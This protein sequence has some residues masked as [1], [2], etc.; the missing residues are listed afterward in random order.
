MEDPDR[1]REI[2]LAD[3]DEAAEQVFQKLRTNGLLISDV[4][5]NFNLRPVLS[6]TSSL[7]VVTSCN[8]P[9]LLMA[10]DARR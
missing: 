6:N 1:N 9:E 8:L 3:D 7:R 4:F 2:E 10:S 5:H